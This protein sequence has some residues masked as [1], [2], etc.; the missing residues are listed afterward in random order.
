LLFIVFCLS[1]WISGLLGHALHLPSVVTLAMW[2]CPLV[3]LSISAVRSTRLPM[4]EV[5]AHG[6]RIVT[7]R[8][9]HFFPF[10][11]IRAVES[12]EGALRIFLDGDEEKRIPVDGL[13][14]ARV[15]ALAEAVRDARLHTA[16]TRSRRR[17][18]HAPVEVPEIA[19]LF[20]R[21][22]RSLAEWRAHV[23]RLLRGSDYRSVGVD[24]EDVERVLGH[25]RATPQQ[26]IG[27]ALAVVHGGDE[28][29]KADVE[30][31]LRI[32][33]E[34]CDDEDASRALEALA[35]G[36]EEAFEEAAEATTRAT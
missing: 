26:R 31:R 8:R 18:R 7:H 12:S 10:E 27:A 2:L 19:R 25:P 33:A 4:V 35:D 13:S 22:G 36:D 15:E 24:P 3:V 34:A 29:G 23:G 5:H 14:P 16:G 11:H 21:G 6:V 1:N 20:E 17:T 32:A 9:E 28:Q 30:R